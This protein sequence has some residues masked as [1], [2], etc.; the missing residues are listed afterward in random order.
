MT[1]HDDALDAVADLTHWF[2]QLVEA[3]TRAAGLTPVRARVLHEIH[4]TG[5]VRQRDLA[6]SARMSP[7]QV[8]VIVDALLRAGL[9]A[10]EPDPDDRRAVRVVLTDQG[11]DLAHNLEASRRRTA[12]ALLGDRPEEDVRRLVADL[13]RLTDGVR[14]QLDRRTAR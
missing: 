12:R 7:Q 11:T 5:P 6:A 1:L 4:T 3:G 2:G 14:E 8:A 13:G 10:R 9:A